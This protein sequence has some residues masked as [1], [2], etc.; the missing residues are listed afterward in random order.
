MWESHKNIKITAQ[1]RRF[2]VKN[3]LKTGDSV[4]DKQVRIRYSV[5]SSEPV[6]VPVLKTDTH[7]KYGVQYFRKSGMI[8]LW[9][10]LQTLYN[11]FINA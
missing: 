8:K 7:K 6:A 10:E 9:E 2:I 4:V 5:T 1:N 11:G 3:G